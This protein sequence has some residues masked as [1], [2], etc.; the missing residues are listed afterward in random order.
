M[1]GEG[2]HGGTGDLCGRLLGDRGLSVCW[3]ERAVPAC[4]EAALELGVGEGRMLEGRDWTWS[5]E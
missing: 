1:D 2:R 3:T 5:W 4:L